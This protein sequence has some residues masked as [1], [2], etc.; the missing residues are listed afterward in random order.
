M[1][2]T[3]RRTAMALALGLLAGGMLTS[4]QGQETPRNPLRRLQG[5]WTGTFENQDVT[6]TVNGEK[7]TG[8][9][10]GE[11]YKATVKVDREATPHAITF[12][13]NEGPGGAQGKT[14]NGIFKFEEGKLVVCIGAP[15]MDRPTEFKGATD[16]GLYLFTLS[17][18]EGDGGPS[19]E[20]QALRRM[21]GTW[22]SEL[23]NG[24]SADWVIRGRRIVV[25]VPDRR[26]VAEATVQPEAKPHAT[27]DF[28]IVEGPDDAKGK[29]LQGIYK[30][31]G[32]ALVFC[33]DGRA[34]SRPTAF[35]ADGGDVFVFEL[36][37]AEPRK[38]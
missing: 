3:R 18:K 36:K 2:T 23:P 30:Q 21:Q 25:E 34:Q 10:V 24:G 28:K 33:I 14:T 11:T 7:V 29:T 22:K 38:E 35:E 4:A 15:G 5:T 20:R 1:L 8:T 13:V 19:P 9:I 31:E 37:K 17:R 16:E 26:Y 32:D 12:H 27:V 6:W